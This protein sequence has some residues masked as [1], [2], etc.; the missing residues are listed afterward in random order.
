MAKPLILEE[1][2]PKSNDVE[3]S[4][5]LGETW[6]NRQPGETSG[7]LGKPQNFFRTT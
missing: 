7:N 1:I 3:T 6:G 2:N 4:G 5:N